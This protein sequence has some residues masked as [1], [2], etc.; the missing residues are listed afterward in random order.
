MKKVLSIEEQSKIVEQLRNRVSIN[1]LREQTGYGVN[2]LKRI[3][4]DNHIAYD[5]R[6][7]KSKEGRC[8]TTFTEVFCERSPSSN[9][10]VRGLI[11][12]HNI[13]PHDKCWKCG[14]SEWLEGRLTLELD[15]INGINSDHRPENLRFLCPN[16]HSQTPTYKGKNINT[17]RIKVSDESLKASLTKN[18]NIRQALICVGLVPKGANYDR[19]KKLLESLN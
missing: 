11:A 10:T 1:H 17:S 4:D 7:Q 9:F 5:T 18:A 19:A 2:V 3:R 14:I 12:K 8:Y 16:C 15:H 13:I 6:K